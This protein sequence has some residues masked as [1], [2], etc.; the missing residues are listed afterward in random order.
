VFTNGSISGWPCYELYDVAV[1]H[2]IRRIRKKSII[3]DAGTD[4]L[5]RLD[6][7]HVQQGRRVGQHG[8]QSYAVVESS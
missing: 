1:A 2:G 5:G 8:R 4:D 3:S 6:R 7:T